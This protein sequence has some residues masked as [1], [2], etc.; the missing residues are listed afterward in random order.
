MLGESY[1]VTDVIS[2]RGNRNRRDLKYG[3]LA[4]ARRRQR[5]VISS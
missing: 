3:A 4:R 2:L 1:I 5:L